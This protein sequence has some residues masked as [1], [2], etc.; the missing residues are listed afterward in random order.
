MNSH[1]HNH[2]KTSPSK[3]VLDWSGRMEE[4]PV[5]ENLKEKLNL[6]QTKHTRF[7]E[8]ENEKKNTKR[9]EKNCLSERRKKSDRQIN[10]FPS[11]V[12]CVM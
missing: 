2:S 3:D 4:T 6:I 11:F 8:N 9:K 12:G 10:R 1:N 5:Y 7:P